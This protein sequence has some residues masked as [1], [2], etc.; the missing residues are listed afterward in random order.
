MVRVQPL[1]QGV[2]SFWFHSL[3]I[4][5]EPA[6][7]KFS[8]QTTISGELV[9]A[10]KDE[11]LCRDSSAVEQYRKVP[12]TECTFWTFNLQVAGSTPA[13]GLYA[14]VVKW[15]NTAV[16]INVKRLVPLTAIF[17]CKSQ[18]AIRRFDSYLPLHSLN[19]SSNNG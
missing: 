15:S 5:F 12:P 11:Q 14:A 1:A 16:Y 3:Q 4:E 2:F 18:T 13:P 9:T 19:T 7:A 17:I 8:V 10:R 6:W